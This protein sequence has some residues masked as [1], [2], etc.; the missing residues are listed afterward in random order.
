MDFVF[1]TDGWVLICTLFAMIYGLIYLRR[2]TKVLYVKMIC[3]SVV[4]AFFARL[5]LLLY[6]ILVQI[7]DVDINMGTMGLFGS[8]LFL[9]SA[10]FGQIDGLVD[11][12]SG[13]FLKTRLLALLAPLSV[14]GLF[15]YYF[16]IYAE[17]GYTDYYVNSLI[18][19]L[20][21]IVC[22]YYNFKH[23]IIYDVEGGIV[24]SLRPYNIAAILYEL[25]LFFEWFWMH[26]VEF[27]LYIIAMAIQGIV[28]LA[29]LPLVRGG[30]RKWTI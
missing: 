10:N 16:H 18:F 23:L 3:W 25:S 19:T 24:R 5:F 15:L 11:D 27:D 29:I 2:N 17:L 7:Y 6:H 20:F 8:L 4:C 9:L 12:G 28:I 1:Y 21:I 30:V 14:L 26:T 22:I 13:R